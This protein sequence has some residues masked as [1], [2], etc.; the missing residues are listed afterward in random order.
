MTLTLTYV[1]KE[2]LLSN[3][4]QELSGGLI[5]LEDITVIIQKEGN[6]MYDFDFEC[7]V[8][9]IVL[10][11]SDLEKSRGHDPFKSYK[12]LKSELHFVL[13]STCVKAVGSAPLRGAPLPKD[14]T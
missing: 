11:D 13:Q 12:A 2:V 6:L 8:K 1:V 5:S 10:S 14:I 9:V 7:V 3:S 4:P